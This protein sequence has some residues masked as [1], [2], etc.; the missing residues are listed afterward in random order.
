[1]NVEYFN[2]ECSK[3][4]TVRSI[5]EGRGVEPEVALSRS[6]MPAARPTMAPRI[7]MGKRHST[8]SPSRAP[9]ATPTA[10]TSGVDSF[11][12]PEA[13]GTSPAVSINPWSKRPAR[14]N[15]LTTLRS[16]VSLGE[17]TCC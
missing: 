1:M 5:L 2:P 8:V 4:R 3:C 16:R 9:I 10:I 13:M 17:R 15:L 7:A 14:R 6:H 11:P 12:P